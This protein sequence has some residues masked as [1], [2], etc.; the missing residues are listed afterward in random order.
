MAA[1]KTTEPLRLKRARISLR[2]R[3]IRFGWGLCLM[4]VSASAWAYRPFDS[5]DADVDQA[6]EFELE[7]GP[8]GSL[9]DGANKYW[10]APAVV[11]NF[12]V[13]DGYE[14]VLQGQ[15]QQLR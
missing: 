8:V 3:A 4:V 6:G 14:L 1:L 15:R 13:K 5:T 10:V 7:L 9:R 12:G 11:A 2:E